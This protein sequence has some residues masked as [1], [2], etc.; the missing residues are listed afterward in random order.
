VSDYAVGSGYMPSPSPMSPSVRYKSGKGLAMARNGVAQESA[1]TDS[2]VKK[3]M[4]V[5]KQDVVFIQKVDAS[6]KSLTSAIT[7][8]VNDRAA[9]LKKC[10]TSNL[11]GKMV[12]NVVISADGKVKSALV[13]TDR[14]RNAK[15]KKCLVETIQKW[16]FSG[17]NASGDVTVLITLNF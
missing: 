13:K 5:R 16:Q 4:E 8:M 7:K 15:L 17:M 14:I 11:R 1:A 3:E 2:S 9:D 6:D 12:L 10:N